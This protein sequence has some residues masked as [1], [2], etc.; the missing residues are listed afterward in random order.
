MNKIYTTFINKRGYWIKDSID[1]NTAFQIQLLFMSMEDCLTQ[2]SVSL[3]LFEHVQLDTNTSDAFIDSL[4]DSHRSKLPFL[5]A[6][7]FVF[8]LDYI[9]K[10]FET[11]ENPAK[12][13]AIDQQSSIK[14]IRKSY[15]QQLPGLDDV[16]D[17]AHHVE[18]IIRAKGRGEKKFTPQ[19]FLQI[20]NLIGNNLTYTAK[21]G[22]I[23]K[24][25]ISEKS[26]QTAQDAV[27]KVHD[28]FH[29]R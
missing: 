27:Q 29:W 10:L 8:A 28:C 1:R 17:S 11:L 24:V 23:Q 14:Q 12:V 18:D 25:E 20:S 16:R 13:G 7:M 3:T 21:D 15:E 26:L 2:A 19:G 9:K 6:H 5:Y 22:K 4:P